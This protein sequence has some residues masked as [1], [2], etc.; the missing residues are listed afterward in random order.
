LVIALI[1]ITIISVNV[2]SS[3]MT[4]R[5]SILTLIGKGNDKIYGYNTERAL[6][7]LPMLQSNL[8]ALRE[9]AFQG[10]FGR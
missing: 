2:G 1:L 7:V 6:E 4:V 8:P 10:G 3:D 5:E 9:Y